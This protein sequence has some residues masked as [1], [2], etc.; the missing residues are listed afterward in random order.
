MVRMVEFRGSLGTVRA[1]LHLPDGKGPH[2]GVVIM[3]G[4][5]GQRLEPGFLFRETSRALE[6]A[7]IAS[8]RFD[9]GGSGES[10]GDFA[11][12]TA[13]TERAD[14]LAALDFMR[15]CDGIDP[16]R[17]GLLGLSFGGFMTACTAGARPDQVKAV[18]LWSAAGFTMQC[19]GWNL[20]PEQ[21]QSLKDRGWL[22]LAGLRLS[23][24]WLD[25]I[26]RH[27]PF[28]E[29]AKYGGP[30]LLIHG[31]RD[32][33]VPLQEAMHWVRTLKK[34]AGAA[35]EHLFIEGAD[36]VFMNC[37]HHQVVIPRTVRWFKELL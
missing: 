35:T 13:S 8:L 1:T 34:R 7:G 22:D 9:F 10:D 31:T 26:T 33:S 37:D 14:A 30:V 21:K 29:I 17:V 18:A 32:G 4:F 5:T 16:A 19:K 20:T 6:A 25:D 24:A 11:D 28:D 27:D 2:S 3:H 15:S 23:Q 12:M 36:H